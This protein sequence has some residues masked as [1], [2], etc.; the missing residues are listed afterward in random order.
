[1]TAAGAPVSVP[2][3]GTASGRAGCTP[4]VQTV[5]ANTVSIC[6]HIIAAAAG[7]AIVANTVAVGVDIIAAAAGNTIV[8]NAVAV[9]INIAATGGRIRRSAERNTLRGSEHAACANTDRRD[10]RRHTKCQFFH[11]NTSAVLGC[12]FD[13]FVRNTIGKSKSIHRKK[14]NADLFGPLLSK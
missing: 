9:G 6:I 11:T 12:G 4:A 3:L 2:V 14:I 7:K 13:S 1:M 8:A 10:G 5:V